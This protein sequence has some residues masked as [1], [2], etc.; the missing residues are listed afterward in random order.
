MQ[1]ID[2]AA[3]FVDDVGLCVFQ[4]EKGGLPS[5][6]GAI[7]GRPGPAPKWGTHDRAYNQAWDW[8]DRL[9][10]KKRLYYGKA[11]G[12]FRMMVSRGLLPYLQA[13]CAPGPTSDDDD[14]LALYE[15]GL[16]PAD[17]K[18]V[19][20]ALMRSGPA[21]TAKLRKSS[22]ISDFRRFDRALSDLQRKFLVAP[23][24]IDHDNAWK[25]TFRYAPLH[26]A[27]PKEAQRAA[28][29][30]S[31]EAM[32]HLLKHYVELTGV[33]TLREPAR[34]F[35]WT[36]DRLAKVAEKSELALEA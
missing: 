1:S 7:A 31:R 24:G 16:L 5:F 4:G 35:G 9:F 2:E 17:A 25:Y 32:A 26:H 23:V 20:E 18:L 27:F 15:D 22:G 8:K 13:A 14:Y 29:L 21:S 36:V 19:Y 33:T 6:Y 28:E 3:S 34:L 10:S 12:E 30:H 11:L